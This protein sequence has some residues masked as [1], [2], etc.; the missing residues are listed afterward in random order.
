[1]V[2]FFRSEIFAWK[3]WIIWKICRKVH[4]P[5]YRNTC[6]LIPRM[7]GEF[8]VF[9][10]QQKPLTSA[11]IIL[12]SFNRSG[13]RRISILH[14]DQRLYCLVTEDRVRRDLVW[15]WVLTRMI[16]AARRPHGVGQLIECSDRN[17]PQMNSFIE[18]WLCRPIRPRR[19]DGLESGGAV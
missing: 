19:A 10:R 14:S 2:I 17:E 4:V 7:D 18:L 6:R 13:N 11:E 5:A 8:N 3:N 15:P 1:M 16:I 9:W 12:H